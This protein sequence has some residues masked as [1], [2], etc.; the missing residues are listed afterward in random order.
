M[1]LMRAEVN[2]SYLQDS[3]VADPFVDHVR[4]WGTSK[5]EAERLWKLSEKLVG[6]EFPY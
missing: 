4:P 6:E 3:R 5:I 2:G 1:V